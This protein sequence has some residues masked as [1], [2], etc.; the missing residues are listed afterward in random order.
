[1]YNL[2]QTGILS[3]QLLQKQLAKDHY[4]WTATHF[5]IMLTHLLPGLVL[6]H[7]G[8]FWHEV[9]WTGKCRAPY[10]V[11]EKTLWIWRRLDGQL[12][13]QYWVRLALWQRVCWH[14]NAQ[15]SLKIYKNNIANDQE[16]KKIAPISHT[17]KSMDKMHKTQTQWMTCL[18]WKRTT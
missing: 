2:P 15:L 12:I 17:L 9:C 11:L 7:G 3:N 5:R 8:W 16:N 13:L 1:M 18:H 14:K 4:F 6:A 10:A